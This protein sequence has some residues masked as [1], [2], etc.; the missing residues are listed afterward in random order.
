M[1]PGFV[2]I[3][4]SAFALVN[5]MEA[6]QRRLGRMGATVE[7]CE[8]VHEIYSS[9]STHRSSSLVHVFTGTPHRCVPPNTDSR[10]YLDGW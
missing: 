7:T 10:N 8:L 6:L 9:G 2:G 4:A 1:S 3:E 5:G